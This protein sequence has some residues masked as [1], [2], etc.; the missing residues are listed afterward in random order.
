MFHG[1]DQPPGLIR[2]AG[3]QDVLRPRPAAG[4]APGVATARV[5][6][7]A[8]GTSTYLTPPAK[9]PEV[10]RFTAPVALP[11]GPAPTKDDRPCIANFTSAPKVLFLYNII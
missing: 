9:R 6:D 5:I 10:R 11:A 7:T 2:G 1:V 8:L 4:S 3:A